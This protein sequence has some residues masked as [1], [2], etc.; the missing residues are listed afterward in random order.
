MLLVKDTFPS[1]KCCS[2]PSRAH[3]EFVERIVNYIFSKHGAIFEEAADSIFVLVSKPVLQTNG[4]A[5]KQMAA[6]FL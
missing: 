5:S 1:H 3:L 6:G 2:C 4:V